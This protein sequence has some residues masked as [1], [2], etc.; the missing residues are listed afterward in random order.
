MSN[1][2]DSL[3]NDLGIDLR[4]RGCLA[5]AEGLGTDHIHDSRNSLGKFPNSTG[6]L[7]SQDVRDVATCKFQ[8]VFKVSY[9][10]LSS[11]RSDLAEKLI[12]S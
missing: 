7:G 1:S 2:S 10:F 3:S 8:T 6:R 9:P 4:A 5:N 11:Q 12:F